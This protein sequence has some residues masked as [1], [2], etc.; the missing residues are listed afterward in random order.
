[1]SSRRGFRRLLLGR[2]FTLC[3]RSKQFQQHGVALTVEFVDEQ[4]AAS[5]SRRPMIAWLTWGLEFG[6]RAEIFPP[7]G[8]GPERCSMKW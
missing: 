8:Y 5:F 6:D 7:R 4:L 2:L 3:A 1:L